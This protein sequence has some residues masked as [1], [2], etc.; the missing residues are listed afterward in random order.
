MEPKF[1]KTRMFLGRYLARIRRFGARR[2][3]TTITGILGGGFNTVAAGIILF[4]P[5]YFKA[6]T[7]TGQV[8]IYAIIGA[9]VYQFIFKTYRAMQV[10]RA[11]KKH[12]LDRKLIERRLINEIDDRLRAGEKLSN[13]R[14]LLENVLEAIVSKTAEKV[15]GY[16]EH[17]KLDANLMVLPSDETL[18]VIARYGNTRDVPKDYAR[19]ERFCSKVLE[20]PISPRVAGDLNVLRRDNQGAPYRDILAV[21][22]LD[23]TGLQAIAIVN[24]DSTEAHHF[25]YNKAAL[26]EL[27]IE[28]SPYIALLR[29]ILSN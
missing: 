27:E 14:R 5:M 8:A 23:D 26:R 19:V 22:V 20:K 13:D 7:V 11:G 2:N 21:P 6:A 25:P 24:V 12:D 17:D 16:K 1:L 3:L 4:V 9:Y 15:G 29:M 18:R 10:D 28:I